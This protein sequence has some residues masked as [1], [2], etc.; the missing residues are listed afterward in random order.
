MGEYLSIEDLVVYQR[1]CASHIEVCALTRSWP[2]EEPYEL[3]AQVNRASNSAP[4][5]LAEKN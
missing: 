2:R 1:L 3:C 4:A 5:Q